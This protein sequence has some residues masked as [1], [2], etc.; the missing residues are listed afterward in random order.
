VCDQTPVRESKRI[1]STLRAG[2]LPLS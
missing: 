2:E 1:A